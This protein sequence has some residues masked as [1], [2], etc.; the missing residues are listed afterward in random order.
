M[1]WPWIRTSATRPSSTAWMKRVKL[2][3]GAR[4]C[5]LLTMDQRISPIRSSRSQRPRLRETGFTHTSGGHCG[6]Y[7]VDFPWA[8]H[9]GSVACGAAAGALEHPADDAPRVGAD[10]GCRR[11]R[12]SRD[13]ENL[14]GGLDEGQRAPCLPRHLGVDQ[15]VLEL[16]RTDAWQV[17]AITG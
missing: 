17:D 5:C 6:T 12:H 10:R 14:A 7:H 4:G 8:M 2:I 15:D 13:P 11:P 16:P 9:A 3:S 1:L